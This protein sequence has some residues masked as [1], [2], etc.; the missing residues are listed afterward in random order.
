MGEIRAFRNRVRPPRPAPK[1][2][3][4]GRPTLRRRWSPEV[5]AIL[6]RMSSHSVF[7]SGSCCLAGRRQ[8]RESFTPPSILNAEVSP[9][10]DAIISRGV[11]PDPNS[12]FQRADEML[13]A[14][15]AQLPPDFLGEVE[16]ATFLQKRFDIERERELV[17]HG[18]VSRTAFRSR[19][20]ARA[21]ARGMALGQRAA[22]HGTRRGTLARSS[23]CS[24]AR[25]RRTRPRATAWP[26]H[27]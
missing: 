18:R 23:A 3:F 7:C 6:A 13:R 5:R 15:G 4:H 11:S 9:E 24:S 26:S 19:Y 10:L 12:R 16:L 25:R 14:L 1:P 21:A 8:S 2:R 20:D 22:L 17:A 27:S